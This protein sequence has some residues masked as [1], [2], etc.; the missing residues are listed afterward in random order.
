MVKSTLQ[1]VL[2][3]SIANFKRINGGS[4]E[5]TDFTVKNHNDLVDAF[6]EVEPNIFYVDFEKASESKE[7]LEIM[8]EEAKDG[9]YRRRLSLLV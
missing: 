5:R 7:L 8:T 2:I 6:S 1:L 9:K 4:G 3:L